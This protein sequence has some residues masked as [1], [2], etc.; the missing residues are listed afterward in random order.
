MALLLFGKHTFHNCGEL[1]FTLVFAKVEQAPN[2]H[3]P[4]QY[5][6]ECGM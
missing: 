6:R 3:R 1:A 2:L 5:Q 4:Q